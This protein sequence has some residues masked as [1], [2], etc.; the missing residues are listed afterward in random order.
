[1]RVSNLKPLA[2]T[3]TA[4]AGVVS[5]AVLAARCH[6][7]AVNEGARVPLGDNK[8]QF[9]WNW[10]K[11][12]WKFYAPATVSAIITIASMIGAHSILSTRNAVAVTGLVSAQREL[13]VLRKSMDVLEPED[14]ERVMSSVQKIKQSTKDPK[15]IES[16]ETILLG[17]DEV[18]WKDSFSGRYFAATTTAVDAAINDVNRELNLGNSVSLN[19]FYSEVGLAHTQMGEVLG[20]PIMSDL[21]EHV[22]TSEVAPNGR[23]CLVL[24]FVNPPVDSYDR[25]WR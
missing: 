11:A 13:G 5:T 15:G 4:A 23:P 8:L 19:Q 3:F 6:Q 9:A 17:D 16:V 20:W 25:V 7:R 24:T 18:L 21:V 10:T 1:M 22:V 2:L 12:N 14:Q